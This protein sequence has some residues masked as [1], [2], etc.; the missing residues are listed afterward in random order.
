M[1]YQYTKEQHQQV[2]DALERYQVKRQDFDTFDAALAMLKAMQP[3]EEN[4]YTRK[5]ESL[6]SQRDVL[7]EALKDLKLR[8]E[9]MFNTYVRGTYT[10]IGGPDYDLAIGLKITNEALNQAEKRATP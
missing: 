4:G 8:Y 2:V 6:I 5:I 9:G 1:M 3:V 10:S 7:L